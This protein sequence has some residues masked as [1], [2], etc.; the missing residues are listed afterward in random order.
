M[1]YGT[2]R[3]RGLGPLQPVTISVRSR[4]VRAPRTAPLH[5]NRLKTN[6]GKNKGK[7][8]TLKPRGWGTRIWLEWSNF[9]DPAGLNR[10]KTF[11][12]GWHER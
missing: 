2:A 4:R 11:S 10:E 12:A 6:F 7:I 5:D 3:E 8:P 1:D 9:Y